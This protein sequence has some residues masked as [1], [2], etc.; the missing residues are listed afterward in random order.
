MEQQIDTL[1]TLICNVSLDLQKGEK[2]YI[3]YGSLQAL[4]LVE[5]LITQASRKGAFV[6][7]CLHLSS[8]EGKCKRLLDPANISYMKEVEEA[9]INYFDAFIYIK[10]SENDYELSSLDPVKRRKIN[11][12]LAPSVDRR[13]N[14]KKWVLLNYPSILDAHKSAMS[15]EE[16][17]AFSL[18][19]M[20]INYEELHKK[21]QPLQQLME[22]TDN[23]RI[24]GPKT[25]ISFSIKGMPAIACTGEKNLPDGEIYTAPLKTSVNGT[26]TFN[27]PSPYQGHIYHH[28]SLTFSKGQIIKAI[29]DEEPDMLTTIFNIDEG[30][31]YVGEFSLGLNPVI[32]KPMGD[33]LFDEKIFGSL[34]FTPGA[35]YDDC[36]NGNKSAIHWDL[37]L[38]QTEAYG[39]GNIFFDGV[40]IRENGL[41]TLPQL[42]ALNG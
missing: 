15:Q 32:K 10:Y 12:A 30:A 35:A 41:F 24:T 27:T 23:V 21:L 38:I 6:Y 26:I 18:R 19:A 40:L 5:R 29:S 2:L 3:S 9:K 39:G 36:N 22:K 11:Q 25:N 17:V 13:A 1:A 16:F 37:V 34:H 4:P 8:L 28:V 33:I 42:Q 31:R 20:T 7:P 14:E